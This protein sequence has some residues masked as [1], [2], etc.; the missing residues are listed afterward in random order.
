[1]AFKIIC[2]STG[3]GKTTRAIEAFLAALGS[4]GNPLF[5][6][7][8]EPDARHFQRELIR[9]A[10]ATAGGA[11][12][13]GVLTGGRVTTFDGLCHELTGGPGPDDHV[14][15][16]GERLLILKAIV[17][18]SGLEHLYPVSLSDGFTAALA[19]L[20]AE[21]ELLGVDALMLC[22]L[23]EPWARGSRRRSNLSSALCLLLERYRTVL[24]AQGLMD[25]ELG[26]RRAL[27]MLQEDGAALPAQTVIVDGFWDFT[28]F[29][30][31]FIAT[32][33]ASER[34]LLVTL[35]Y[36]EGRE[37][38]RAV[39]AH[40]DRLSSVPECAVEVVLTGSDERPAAL[41][42]LTDNIFEPG[43]GKAGAGGVVR[44]LA[45]AGRRGQAEMIADEILRLFREKQPLD[46][47]AVVCRSLGQDMFAVAAA[48]EEYGVP[49]DLAAPVPLAFT[50]VGR[51][52]IAA[53]EFAAGSRSRESFFAF[54]RSPLLTISVDTIDEFDRECRLSGV[55][56]APALLAAWQKKTGG[57]Q[58]LE[59]LKRLEAAAAGG[60]RALGN[61]LDR[62]IR[63][64]LTGKVFAAGSTAGTLGGDIP[65]IRCLEAL[66]RGA[67]RAEEAAGELAP[68]GKRI[69]G[70]D[71]AQML[72]RAVRRATFRPLAGDRRGCV[73]LLDPHR[74][75]NRRFNTVFVC[76]LLEKEFPAAGREDLFF[77]ASGREELREGG[78]ELRPRGQR[79]EEE[80]F[81]FMR[82]LSR[83]DKLVYLCHQS[84]DAEGKPTIPSLFINDV[85]DLF[86]KDT[87]DNRE[88][89][90]SMLA[91][92]PGEA[93]TAGETVR[94]LA[95]WA[96]TRPESRLALIKADPA[97]LGA[98]LKDVFGAGAARAGGVSEQA[99]VSRLG[100]R[101]SFS[102]S[103]LQKYL[104]C[105]FRY[106][107][108]EV[109]KPARMDPPA[110]QLDRGSRLHRILCR[111]GEQLKRSGIH[112]GGTGVDQ[113][114]AQQLKQQMADIV[115]REFA[116]A[117]SDLETEIMRTELSLRLDRYIERERE[118]R[119]RLQNYDFEL[120]F[121]EK[122]G[123]CGGRNSTAA[124][125]SMGDF[126]L[127]GRLDRIDW[128][129]A[130][131]DGL[132][133]NHALVVDYKFGAITQ[134]WKKFKDKK[135][136]QIPVYIKALELMG[137]T[138]IGGEY[139]SFRKE[140]RRGVYMEGFEDL[141]GVASGQIKDDD[142]V[143]AGTFQECLKAAEA[144]A[145]EA[146]AGIRGG[147]FS[148]ND[149]NDC[150]WCKLEGVCRR[151]SPEFDDTDE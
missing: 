29:Q 94:S 5:I 15:D 142:I 134:G 75:L 141:A 20:F 87:I 150:G 50:A 41:V 71:A 63:S 27:A 132:I 55:R 32:L 59:E 89:P 86:N 135:E 38:C 56:D 93:L 117:G 62:L 116:G 74:A 109:L 13:P 10:G 67:A 70:N 96:R 66:C 114:L 16:S 11:H 136:I 69:R 44:T 48:L 100:E 85:R 1:M 14:I 147:D 37:S 91:P 17:A 145:R 90:I 127:T 79:L 26:Q 101:Q 64:L 68:G 111:F 106:F 107:V 124:A 115:A 52:V 133:N 137:M 121:G 12:S 118:S 53:L 144:L 3:S 88:R 8:S 84:C 51:T 61:E 23:L 110:R 102:V 49:F 98:R 6:A 104:Q 65:A 22:R 4:G 129:D 18:V 149:V 151:Q 138:A 119:R 143:D 76:G 97:G 78:L 24:E 103:R 9:A 146:V 39:A 58:A 130:D 33:A 128:G 125:L 28:P 122:R 140:E 36:V 35:P 34:K 2:G 92:G 46:T 112:L 123:G 148:I 45:G 19:D 108:E 21:L 72:I 42:H 105:P 60:L 131:D 95:E 99:I 82:V 73:R 31:E 81:L 80:R 54:L 30:H 139:F 40:F 57:R 43:A 120:G 47:I 113:G 126:S 25:E 77:S 83:A 7:P